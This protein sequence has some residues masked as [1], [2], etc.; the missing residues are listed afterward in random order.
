MR[1]DDTHVTGCGK[2][3]WKLRA[4]HLVNVSTADMSPYLIA[5]L[6][7]G[8]WLRLPLCACSHAA[9]FLVL[10]LEV[11][12]GCVTSFSVL[13]NPDVHSICVLSSQGISSTRI[14]KWSTVSL[15][16]SCWPLWVWRSQSDWGVS[17]THLLL[18]CLLPCP[19]HIRSSIEYGKIW[20]APV[21]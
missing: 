1:Y 8:T 3:P 12:T 19:V 14:V 21:W 20:W 10:S 9:A 2:N 18:N 4:E 11:P 16:P 15:V 13:P 7:T 6:Y 17:A 5:K